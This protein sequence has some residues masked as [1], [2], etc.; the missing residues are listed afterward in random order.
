[1]VAIVFVEYPESV[2]STAAPQIQ[3]AIDKS[4]GELAIQDVRQRLETGDMGLLCIDGRAWCVVEFMDYPQYR[5]LK[6]VYLAGEDMAVWLP[7]LLQFLERWA[8]ENDMRYI[9]QAGRPGWERIL[10]D[11]G[12]RKTYT[13]MTKELSHGR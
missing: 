13:I 7:D 9:E 10:S 11:Y 1:M 3:R 6:V 12:Y 8:M 5:S 4:T 2:W